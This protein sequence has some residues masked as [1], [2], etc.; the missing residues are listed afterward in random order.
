MVEVG[1]DVA[2][3]VWLRDVVLVMDVPPGTWTAY[4][5]RWTYELVTISKGDLDMTDLGEENAD[6]MQYHRQE[7]AKARQ[8]V[9]SE[10]FLKLPGSLD[11]GEDGMMERF[12][13]VV[14][15]RTLGDALKQ[16]LRGRDSLTRFK[17]V[18]QEHGMIPVW[19][20]FRER[21][22]EDLAAGWLDAHG[23][24]YRRG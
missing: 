22:L 4:L 15:D 11:I 12:S 7:V 8:V 19:Y 6:L 24:A 18:L 3:A 16:A 2:P 17:D 9:V 14:Q 13:S 5:N 21:A 20:A 10:D 23:I 1:R